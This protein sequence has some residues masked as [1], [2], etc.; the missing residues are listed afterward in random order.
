MR[1]TARLSIVGLLLARS[2]SMTVA[3]MTKSRFRSWPI[4]ETG[5]LEPSLQAMGL[6]VPAS[7]IDGTSTDKAC[8]SDALV[9]VG[10]AGRGGT[11]S[12]ISESGL[13]ITNHHVAL[14][15]VRRASTA[16]KDLLAD[17]F[18]A[19]SMADE[20]ADADYEVWITRSCVDVSDRL[21][22]VRAEPDPLVRANLVRDRRQE[23]AREAEAGGAGGEP[24]VRCEVQEMWPD[25][26]YVLFTYERLRDVRLVYAP[27]MSLGCFGGDTDNFEWPRHTADFTLLRAYVAPDGSAAEHSP[28]NVP[29]KPQRFLRAATRGVSPGDFVCLLGFPGSTMRYA[30]ASRLAYSDQV[31]VPQ[32]V[33]DFGAKLRLIAQHATDRATALKLGLAKKGLANEH[34]RSVGKRVMMQKLRLEAERRAEEEALCAARPEAAPLLGRLAEVYATLREGATLSEALDGMRGVYHGSTLLAVGHAVHEAAVEAAKPDGERETAYRARNLPFLVKRLAKRLSDLHPPHEAALLRRACSTAAK[35]P[36]GLLPDHLAALEAT[37]VALEGGAA[38][39]PALATL[40]ADDLEKLL[41]GGG[42]LVQPLLAGEGG[43]GGKGDGGAAEA[44]CRR[45]AAVAAAAAL[46]PAYVADRDATKALLSERDQ[47]IAKLLELQRSVATDEA[48]YPDANGCLRLSAGHVEGYSAADAVQHT[49]VTTLGGLVD[50]HLE[51]KLSGAGEAVADLVK[52][53]GGDFDCPQRLVD[54]C[55]ADTAVAA[56]PCCVCYSTDTVGGNSG[57]PVLD[58]NGDFVAINFDRQRLGLMNEFKWSA[59]YSRSIGTDVRYILLL[60]GQYDGAQWLVDE[61]VG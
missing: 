40:A 55:A 44:V 39:L 35:L 56:T 8:L 11:G 61:M 53:E 20:I 47:L 34:K 43:E 19:R 22:D 54:L 26:T 16:G 23:L 27:P 33:S 59:E 15:A 45:D 3:M 49:P 2:L 52:G 36:L 5:A 41:S 6:R 28:D 60:V 57:S 58:A 9:S 30:P 24:S 25:R 50:K 10:P 38:A 48:F 51:A 21:A 14:D 31:A 32:L 17:G 37:A 13:I 46:Y 7:E 42:D 29:Y 4:T 18:V 12:F 1:W